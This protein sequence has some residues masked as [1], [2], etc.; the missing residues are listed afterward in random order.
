MG[1][2]G[3]YLFTP[4]VHGDDRGVFLEWFQEDALAATGHRL[5]LAQ[6]NCSVSAK[7]VLRGLH[8]AAV[9]P[10]Q[11]KYVTCVS[12]AVLDVTVDLRLGSPTF[13]QWRSVRLDAE[14][15]QAVFLAEGLGHAFLS[16][17]DASTVV[18]LCSTPYDPGREHGVH[19]LDPEL[20]IAW[21]GEAPLLS[22][23][24]AAAPSLAEAR[25]RGLLPEYAECVRWYGR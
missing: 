1:L 17:A 15:R 14:S 18:Y 16:L 23:K 6:G 22:P 24:D 3:A 19:P 2:A 12:G 4:K 13:G 5:P 7:G 11:A 25:E 9:P 10:G 20:G 21:P 8:F